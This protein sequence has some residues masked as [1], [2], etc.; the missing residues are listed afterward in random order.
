MPTESESTIITETDTPTETV[1]ETE[2]PTR[3]F[4]QE[5][6]DVIIK[7]RLA[8]EKR[9]R[10][11]E[12]AERAKADKIS[13]LEGEEKLKAMHE[14]ELDALRKERDEA[15]RQT[16]VLK[17]GEDLAKKGYDPALASTLLGADDDTTK[18]NIDAFD[19]AV[20]AEVE[21][22]MQA[23]VTRG[24]PQTPGGQPRDELDIQM[25]KAFGLR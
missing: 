25:R 11:K 10:E 20:K 5:E 19:K 16:R 12:D 6:V 22:R 15:V 17:V 21:R 1:T 9:A 7:E 18:A 2:T 8:K 3:T 4:T 14:S 23:T 13:R 24:A